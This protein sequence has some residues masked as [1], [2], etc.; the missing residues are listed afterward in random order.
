M[1]VTGVTAD[2][3]GTGQGALRATSGGFERTRA[4]HARAPIED[5]PAIAATTATAPH[6]AVRTEPDAFRERGRQSD[7]RLSTADEAGA[8]TV[9]G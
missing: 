7:D 2:M 3:I 9:G 6:T 8:D 5:Q 1:P 4:H